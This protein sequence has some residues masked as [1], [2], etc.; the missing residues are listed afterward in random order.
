MGDRHFALAARMA[1]MVLASLVAAGPAART[2][3]GPI[4]W[5]SFD[6]A[7]GERRAT[8]RAV[9]ISDAIEGNVTRVPGVRGRAVRLDG[10]TSL[11]P[12]RWGAARS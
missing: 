2:Q 7:D 9:G 4:A 11:I 8:D 3:D 1:L 5:R 12:N 10:F 6:E